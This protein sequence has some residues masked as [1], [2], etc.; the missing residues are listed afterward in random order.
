MP[1]QHVYLVVQGSYSAPLLAT[2]VWQIG[3][4]FRVSNTPADDFGLLPTDVDWADAS[5]VID[6]TNWVVETNYE[7]D[8]PLGSSF[9]P[10]TWL[11]QIAGQ[12]VDDWIGTSSMFP[13]TTRIDRLVAY[14]MTDGKVHEVGAGPA[15]ATLTYKTAF[16][17]TGSSSSDSLPPQNSIV[18][19]LVTPVSG[20]KGK[21]RFYMP[22]P[23]ETLVS[24]P[25]GLL[26]SGACTNQATAASTLL[27][28]LAI[29]QTVP[30]PIYLNAIV[31]GA[32]W[33]KYGKVTGVRVGNVIDTQRRRRAQITETYQER[34]V[35]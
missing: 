31:T 13:T 34:P 11:D 27:S 16:R 1:T 20:R 19:S 24:V 35:T 8:L 23:P 28:N 26:S 15:K 2:E 33:T 5:D 21:G 18:A 14:G 30:I 3:M 6:A 25:G 4:R 32:P 17:P 9:Q 22:A 7:A 12:A 10:Q 29:D